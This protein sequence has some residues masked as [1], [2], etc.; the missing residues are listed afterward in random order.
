[1]ARFTVEQAER[2]LLQYPNLDDS[3]REEMIAVIEGKLPQFYLG[4]FCNL[5]DNYSN[6]LPLEDVGMLIQH[7]EVEWL[8]SRQGPEPRFTQYKCQGNFVF[9]LSQTL[10]SAVSNEVI[11][12]DALKED[13]EI[14]RH[15]DLDF[16]VGDPRNVERL[17]S[18]N[19]ILNEVIAYLAPVGTP[20]QR[21]QAATFF[22]T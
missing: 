5:R 3:S 9:G 10:Q 4:Q 1:M 13:I 17:A 19:G 11:K 20:E 15:S 7:Q 22:F 18:V 12:D 14:F 2:V 6:E 16:Q 21:I 8:K